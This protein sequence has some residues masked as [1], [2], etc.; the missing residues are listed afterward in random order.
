MENNSTNINKTNNHLSPKESLNSDR[1]QFHQYQENEHYHSIFITLNVLMLNDLRW[2]VIVCF[3][4][5]RVIVVHHWNISFMHIQDK[6]N[7]P[8]S[9]NYAEMRVE[10]S[11]LFDDV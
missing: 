3:V 4:D 10:W 7:L 6:K 11:L 2:E 5:V 1:Q 9:E 8:I